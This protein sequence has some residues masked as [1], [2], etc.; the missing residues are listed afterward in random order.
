MP[1]ENAE[2]PSESL[3]PLNGS[4]DIAIGGEGANAS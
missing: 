1:A 2:H 3:A 4:V